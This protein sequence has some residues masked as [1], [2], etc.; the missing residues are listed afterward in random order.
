MLAPAVGCDPFQLARVDGSALVVSVPDGAQVRRGRARTEEEL[1]DDDGDGASIPGPTT[2]RL[3]L[4]EEVT[5]TAGALRVL[6]SAVESSARAPR[7]SRERGAAMHVLLAA[8]LH[9]AVLGVA[10]RGAAAAEALAD[11]D[12][13]DSLRRSLAS[14]ERRAA[15]RPTMLVDPDTGDGGGTRVNDH[16]GNGRAGGGARAAGESGALG[17]RLSRAARPQRYALPRGEPGPPSLSRDEVTRDAATF[18]MVGLLASARATPSAPFGEPWARGADDIAARGAMYSHAIGE[19]P[20][21]GG[22]GLSGIGEGGGGEGSGVGLGGIGLGHTWGPSGH[23]TGGRGDPAPW[24]I[25]GSFGHSGGWGRLS[26]SRRT[27]GPIVRCGCAVSVSG[28]L[29]PEVVQRIVRQSFGRFRLCYE[30]GL[31]SKPALAGRVSTRFL[32][33]A[34]GLVTT[35]QNAGSDL[36]DP[37]VVSCVVAAFGT[38]QFPEPPD[39]A[40]VAVTY[41]VV[42]TPE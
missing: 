7:R 26:G 35:A 8:C 10:W 6:V 18:G 34:N 37:A 13:A 41:P 16:P 30:Q 24:S 38:L 19:S 32:I 15:A 29:P 14:A 12:P 31:R 3:S 23:G 5:M 17:D 20:G 42:F 40:V 22:L 21:T 9:A 27:K 25:S 4:G 39:E 1:D 11:D 2:L 28:R 33:G 36:P